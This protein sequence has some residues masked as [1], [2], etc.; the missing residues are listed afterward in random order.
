MRYA[1]YVVLALVLATP[2]GAQQPPL[3][4][5]QALELARLHSPLL[6]VAAGHVRVAEGLSR[7]R[8]A[9]LN[10]IVELRQENLGG[11]LPLDR[12]ATVTLPLDLVLERRAL[13]AAGR[14]T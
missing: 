6:P 12:F 2:A 7:E 13:R 10:P 3:S 5:R 4:L 1:H 9:P 8:S 14:Q 11:V